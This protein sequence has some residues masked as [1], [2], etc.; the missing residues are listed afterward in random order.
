MPGWQQGPQKLAFIFPPSQPAQLPTWNRALS[1]KVQERSQMLTHLPN[2]GTAAKCLRAA[3]RGLAGRPC[4]AREAGSGGSFKGQASLP[5]GLR[6]Q[7]LE[8]S[9]RAPGSAPSFSPTFLKT[10]SSSL[11]LGWQAGF[12]ESPRVFCLHPCWCAPRTVPGTEDVVE[13]AAVIR[14]CCVTQLAY[15]PTLSRCLSEGEC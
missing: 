5:A 4:G 12:L 8:R 11:P 7:R 1:R 2:T 15:R 14:L 3:G 13:F 9:R 6:F 10:I